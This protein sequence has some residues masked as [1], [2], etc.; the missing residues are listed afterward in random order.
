MKRKIK[1]IFKYFFFLNFCKISFHTF[2]Y[3]YRKN[4]KKKFYGIN[5]IYI[6]LS[7]NCKNCGN[8]AQITNYK[9]E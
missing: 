4:K 7:Y 9:L 8:V 1:I 2:R 5:W 6:D 3:F